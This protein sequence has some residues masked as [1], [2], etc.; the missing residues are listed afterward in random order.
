STSR[1]RSPITR[2]A[3]WRPSRIPTATTCSS[4]SPRAP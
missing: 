3:A 4:T 1:A 2:G